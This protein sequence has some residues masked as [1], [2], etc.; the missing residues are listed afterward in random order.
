MSARVALLA[1]LALCAAAPAAAQARTPVVQAHRGG[2][3]VAGE[4]TYPEN[5]LPAFRASAKAGFVLELDTRVTADGVIV[6]HDDT[7]DRTTTCTGRAAS[8][9]LLEI[10]SCPSDFVGSPGS[11]LG[12]RPRAGAAAPPLLADVLAMA[13]RERARVNVELNDFDAEG[14]S[15][16]RV[17]D[18]IAGS[19]IAPR[20]LIVQSF[21]PSNLARAKVR[22]PRVARSSLALKAF[23][24]GGIKAAQDAGSTWVSP[25]WPISRS[26]VRKAHAR[27]LKV[28]PFTLDR[29]RDVRR[30]AR[31]GVD[32]LL[33]DDPT[34]ARR[35][36][37]QLAR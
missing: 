1:A 8:M 24:E 7:L 14:R 25:E 31:I 18:V 10:R 28:A 21:F 27:G 16:D 12:A 3:F 6:L 35:V 34:M 20:R 9:T 36:L 30:A 15:A 37:R 13:R 11:Q 23:G 22:L 4:A 2:S 5:T 32:A 26:Y 17:L 33:T 29:A 19:G